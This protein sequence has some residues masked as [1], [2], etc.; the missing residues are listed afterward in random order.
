MVAA[1]RPLAGPRALRLLLCL[2]L[3]V[4]ATSAD[5]L[6]DASSWMQTKVSVSRGERRVTKGSRR[7]SSAALARGHCGSEEGSDSAPPSDLGSF[8]QTGVSVEKPVVARQDLVVENGVLN[9]AFSL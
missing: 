9:D 7:C 2:L 3:C 8:L 4:V 1:W 5:V 6:D